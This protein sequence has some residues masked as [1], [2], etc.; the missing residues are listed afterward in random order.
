MGSTILVVE[1]NEDVA[2]TIARMLTRAEYEVSVVHRGADALELVRREHPDLVIL[3]IM[4]P[5]M[6]GIDVCRHMRARADMAV[7]PVLFLTARGEMADKID[8][9]DVG[10]DD[11][12][13]KP[14]DMRELELRVRAL[15]RRVNQDDTETPIEVIEVG[16]LCLNCRTFEISTPERK[17]LLTPVKFEL[18]QFLMTDPEHTFSAEELL[19]Q[20][21]NYPPGT[22]MPDLVRVHVKNVRAKI[23]P[24]T[25]S[26]IYL[27][28]ILRRGYLVSGN[29]ENA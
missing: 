20:V 13:T 10:A 11:Y 24:D 2:D 9:F 8:G 4:M 17:E 23:E 27:R 28:N 26:P 1:D 15:L 22:G 25:K 3:D 29:A 7:T 21:W 19:Q 14:F 16:S 18:M 6:S 5:G 12:L